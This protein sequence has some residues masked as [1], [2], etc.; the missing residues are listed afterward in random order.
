AP[1]QAPFI[2]HWPR[3]GDRLALAAALALAALSPG[4]T[5]TRAMVP[6]PV[7]MQDERL[8][9]SYPVLPDSRST[10]V[11]VLFATTRAPAPPGAAER[12]TRHAGDGVRLGVVQ[13][14]LGEP[15]WS[16]EDLVES[17]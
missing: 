16:F 6:S 4:C 8:D 14:Q 17:D 13:V 11:N 15:E 10:G 1:G 3:R 5:T 9:F 7:V 12:F 2:M